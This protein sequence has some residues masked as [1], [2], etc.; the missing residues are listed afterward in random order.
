MDSIQH[1]YGEVIEKHDTSSKGSAKANL[2]DKIMTRGLLPRITVNKNEK[3]CIHILKPCD[4][5]CSSRC[6]I[7]IPDYEAKAEYSSLGDLTS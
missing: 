2:L 1:E 4:L 3:G 6:E 5:V 7:N